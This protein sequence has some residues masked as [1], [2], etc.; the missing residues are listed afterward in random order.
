ME[1]VRWQRG[2]ES[3]GISALLHLGVG[4][5]LSLF[6]TQCPLEAGSR[7]SVASRRSPP[8]RRPK[9]RSSTSNYLHFFQNKS[10]WNK[11]NAT[12]YTS[13]ILCPYYDPP[14]V[15][16]A[17]WDQMCSL[18]NVF[19]WFQYFRAYTSV[20]HP[21]GQV[22]GARQNIRD[23]KGKVAVRHPRWPC[24][25]LAFTNT[26]LSNTGYFRIVRKVQE[27][28]PFDVKTIQEKT[29]G[30]TQVISSKTGKLETLAVSLARPSC[31]CPPGPTPSC[32][33]SLQNLTMSPA[34]DQRPTFM[35]PTSQPPPS[36]RVLLV[37]FWGRNHAHT[38]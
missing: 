28:G 5:S 36:T 3:D 38:I 29:R 13:S 31:S 27:S 9:G 8:G 35:P 2:W 26:L 25:Y 37:S 21:R 15:E 20:T 19:T 7:R 6:K 33:V 11:F 18:P 4:R 34:P 1:Y 23:T 24:L 12:M 14:H 30:E 17:A 16:R 22:E 10:I 32:A